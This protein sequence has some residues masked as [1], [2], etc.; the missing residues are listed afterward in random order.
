[1]LIDDV[2]VALR[3]VS[4]KTDSEVQAMI[5]AAIRDMRRVGI[6]DEL[7]VADDEDSPMDPMVKA[8]VLMYCKAN[9]GFDN[10]DSDRYW[11]RYNWTVTSMLNSSMNEV[12][13]A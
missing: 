13:G 9:Y 2:R 7:L 6:R 4:S 5:D 12:F 10:S 1:M 11:A 8:A 3:V